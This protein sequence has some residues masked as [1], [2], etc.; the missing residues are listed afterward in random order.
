[1]S[2]KSVKEIKDL[3]KIKPE[4]VDEDQPLSR[5][6]YWTLHD[7]T[8]VKIKN[9]ENSHLLNIVLHVSKRL[10]KHNLPKKH[11]KVLMILNEELKSRG[12]K[13]IRKPLPFI[14]D[15]GSMKIWDFKKNNIVDYVPVKQN[16]KK[17]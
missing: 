14:S 7:G 5:E 1:L 2:Y 11:S 10:E 13:R 3:L 12:L 4:S 6:S 9:L 8:K 15:D 17:E 16:K